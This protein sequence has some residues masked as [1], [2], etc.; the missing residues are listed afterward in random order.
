MASLTMVWACVGLALTKSLASMSP[1]NKPDTTDACLL[2]YDVATT[3]CVVT[4]CP[5]GQSVRSSTSTL[6]C[7]SWTSLVAH[8]SGTHAPSMSPDSNDCSVVA[9]SCGRIDTSPPPCALVLRP[10][11]LSQERS[12]T[13]C[14]L[15]SCGVAIFLP[16]RSATLLI[17]DLT[18]SDA[19]PEV[20]PAMILTAEPCVCAQA[21]MVGLGPT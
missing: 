21:V 3:S 8:G 15:P 7:P 11:D 6:P 4:N 14:V 16:L 5:C 1:F 10:C 17:E 19:P 20:A 18:T 12:E 2:R 9:L 13:S